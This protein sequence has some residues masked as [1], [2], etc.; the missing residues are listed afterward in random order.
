MKTISSK[1]LTTPSF[2]GW[3]V[4]IYEFMRHLKVRRRCVLSFPWI[5]KQEETIQ[6]CGRQ[7]LGAPPISTPWEAAPHDT[8]YTT[9][10][11]ALRHHQETPQPAGTKPALV[12]VGT[13][14]PSGTRH[15]ILGGT[16]ERLVVSTRELTSGRRK[17]VKNRWHLRL[18]DR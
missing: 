5:G 18:G 3:I 15:D 13:P 2:T 16:P 6:V 10:I 4:S 1:E 17:N 14:L 8:E 7:G 9:A 11:A 12:A